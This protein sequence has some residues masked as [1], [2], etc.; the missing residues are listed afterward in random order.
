[1]PNKPNNLPS[2]AKADKAV[3]KRSHTAKHQSNKKIEPFLTNEGKN[4]AENN[5]TTSSIDEQNTHTTPNAAPQFAT[6]DIDVET[7]NKQANESTVAVEEKQAT[8]EKTGGGKALALLAILISLGLGGAGYYFGQQQLTEIQ[9]KFTALETQ[10]SST[11]QMTGEQ[12]DNKLLEQFNALQNEYSRLDNQYK[13]TLE[14]VE[15]LQADNQRYQQQ[16]ATL[17]TQLNNVTQLARAANKTQPTSWV[18]SEANFLLASAVQKLS[19]NNDLKTAIVLLREAESALQTVTTP[20]AF[21]L[22]VAIKKDLKQLENIEPVDQDTIMQQLLQL[23]GDVD[24]LTILDLAQSSNVNQDVS[25]S[26]SMDDW[27]ENAEKTATSFLNHFIR[28][29]PRDAKEKVLLAPNQEVYL[30]ENIRLALQV[31][32]LSVPRQQTELYRKSLENVSTWVR[33]YFDTDSSATKRFLANID[34]LMEQ[35]IFV[36]LPTDLESLQLLKAMPATTEPTQSS[37]TN[38]VESEKTTDEQ[39]QQ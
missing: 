27:R 3:K 22:R 4:M 36:D 15:T 31:A 17:Q 2:K 33:S 25:L 39:T 20:E 19:I 26:D 14:K 10:A 16:F 37:N 29:Q 35:S 21:N 32:I 1:M 30:R 7:S 13:S 5:A 11:T 6:E 34:S 38:A 24:S 9:Q 18:I 8:K 28:I 23:A 12:T